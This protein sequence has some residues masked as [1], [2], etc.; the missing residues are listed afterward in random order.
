MQHRAIAIGVLAPVLRAAYGD[1]PR[2]SRTA[3]ACSSWRAPSSGFAGGREW[4]VSH[5]RLRRRA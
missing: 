2:S 4:L 1:A 5:Y 3:G